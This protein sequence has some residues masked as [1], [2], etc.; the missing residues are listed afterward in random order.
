LSRRVV[1]SLLEQT[2]AAYKTD[3]SI[4]LKPG[5][6]RAEE[7]NAVVKIVNYT[8]VE[9]GDGRADVSHLSIDRIA[10]GKIDLRLSGQGEA[11]ARLRGREYGVPYRLSPHTTFSIKDSLVPLQFVSEGERV[12]LRATPG[13]SLP[14]SMRFSIRVAGRDVGINHNI[15]VGLDRWLNRVEI[16]SFFGR[17]VSLPRKMEVDAGGNL[18]VTRKQKINFTLS[19]MRVNA[20]DNAIDMIADAMFS[21]Q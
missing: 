8:D 13:A 16:P 18:Y 7:I 15:R 20:N 1:S 12:I 9:G 21:T 14:I 17:E 4:R 5:R 3:F 6:A 11:D 2:A 19:K 10:D